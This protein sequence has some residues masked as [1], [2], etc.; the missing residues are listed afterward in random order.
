M[1]Y[2]SARFGSPSDFG[3][4]HYLGPTL[5]SADNMNSFSN[6]PPSLYFG[7]LC[8]PR[9]DDIFPFIHFNPVY[10]LKFPQGFFN[11]E[12]N[13]GFLVTSP[14]TAYSLL[15]VGLW[16]REWIKARIGILV[17]LLASFG[18]LL[19]FIE[20]Y[21]MISTTQRYQLDFAPAILLGGVIG[22]IHLESTIKKSFKNN[23][24]RNISRGAEHG[25]FDHRCRP[26]GFTDR[27]HPGAGRR[28]ASAARSRTT[29]GGAGRDRRSV[30][31]EADRGRRAAAVLAHPG[32]T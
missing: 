3:M 16:K 19:M 21:M 17:S 6:L 25:G 28:D 26:G 5:H 31:S 1:A 12:P 20:K 13:A 4:L 24:L 30:E 10:P 7:I 8:P 29:A 15:F 32:H 2:N 23:K 9:I 14:I 22:C 11:E 18:L 27:T